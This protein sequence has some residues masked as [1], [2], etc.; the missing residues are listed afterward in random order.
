MIIIVLT[1]VP[2]GLRGHLTRWLLEVAPG[3]YVGKLPARVRDRLWGQ[4]VSM[5][6]NGRAL[7]IHSAANEQ[8]LSFRT[9]GHSW[10]PE[11]VDGIRLMRRPP[12]DEQAANRGRPPENWSIAARR[13]RFGAQLPRSSGSAEPKEGTPD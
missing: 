13:R 11:D 1:A 2:T 8:G 5:M 10:E 9:S 12:I 4:I 6:G 3:V 7:M